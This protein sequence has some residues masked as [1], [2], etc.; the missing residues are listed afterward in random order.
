MIEAGEGQMGYL[1][2]REFVFMSEC[3]IAEVSQK[4]C[5]IWHRMLLKLPLLLVQNDR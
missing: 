5:L 3:F 2:G 4:V 1:L